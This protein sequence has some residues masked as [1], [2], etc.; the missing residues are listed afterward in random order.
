MK[1]VLTTILLSA[2]LT[3]CI[4]SQGMKK[5][6]LL[7]EKPTLDL[8]TTK[9]VDEYFQCIKPF[10]LHHL[11]YHE[12]KRENDIRLSST[13]NVNVV[14]FILDIKKAYKGSNILFYNGTQTTFALGDVL[15]P[16]ENCAKY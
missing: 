1:K 15:Y 6:K 14:R 4:G 3:A 2:F 5:D 9:T 12:E 7:Q 10:W 13:P 11:G 8:I 16:I